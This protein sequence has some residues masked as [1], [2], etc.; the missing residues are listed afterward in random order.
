MDQGD[1]IVRPSSK[2]NDHLTV[3]WKVA[4]DVYQH[5]D[6][7][8]EGKE[9][10]FSLGQSL[11]IGD[12][13][14]EDLDEIVARYINPMAAHARDVLSFRYFRDLGLTEQTYAPGKER[15]RADEMIKDDKK[16]NPSKIHYFVSCSREF[17]GKFMLSYLPR[18]TTKHEYL[19]VTPDGYRF[20][21][22]VFDGLTS[23]FRWFKEHFR[24][25][26]PGTPVSN[27]GGTHN[28]GSI[29]SRTPGYVGATTPNVN[30]AAVNPETLHRVAQ[31]MPSHML[32]NLSKAAHFQGTPGPFG[33]PAN[34][35]YTPSGQTPFMTPYATTP[36]QPQTPR[37]SGTPAPSGSSGTHGPPPG[38]GFAGPSAP[39][40]GSGTPQ[41]MFRTPATPSMSRGPS[42]SIAPQS[43]PYS[44][45]PPIV[46]A[47]SGPPAPSSSYGSSRPHSQG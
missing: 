19:T 10:A 25:P 28:S 16:K 9:N 23:L 41:G 39:A 15:E 3:T 21:G 30:L 37:Y 27:R 14:F 38:V 44:R 2:G 22:Q 26:I 13:E 24:D 11:L 32:Q 6:I 36:H 40:G 42:S 29:S 46:G 35:P 12:E 20:R 4:D 33:Y 1:V 45:H 5:V 34:T 7:R 18:T 47:G 43:S 31:S 8:E 17:P